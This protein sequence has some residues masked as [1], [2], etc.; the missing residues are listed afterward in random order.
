M[1]LGFARLGLRGG[2]DLQVADRLR[3]LQLPRHGYPGCTPTAVT[4]FA[5]Y[6]ISRR[7]VAVSSSGVLVATGK[8]MSSALARTSG[9]FSIRAISSCRRT[10]TACGM[11]AG[12]KY[13]PQVEGGS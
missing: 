3:A 4:I 9:E 12:P 7:M 11:P 10:T 13:P 1:A 8:P 6:S 5:V 2:D